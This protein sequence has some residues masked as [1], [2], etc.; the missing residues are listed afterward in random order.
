MMVYV[1]LLP[2]FAVTA[3]AAS[4]RRR[5]YDRADADQINYISDSSEIS[6]EQAEKLFLT[7]VET[8]NETKTVRLAP[9]LW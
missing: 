3:R 6:T 1:S 9:L 2:R 5:V 4:L 8:I 7:G